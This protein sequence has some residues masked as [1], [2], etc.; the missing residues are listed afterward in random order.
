MIRSEPIQGG[1]V[2]SGVRGRF[3]FAA[4]VSLLLT[5][6]C[7]APAEPLTGSTL[8]WPD[9]WQERAVFEGP[10]VL[11]LATDAEQAAAG[12]D[13]YEDMLAGLAEV[14][15]QAPQPGLL[16][17]L[18]EDDA[19]SDFELESLFLQLS[20][21]GAPPDR[22]ERL[23]TLQ[24]TTADTLWALL[25][26]PHRL[27]PFGDGALAAH[28]RS[29]PRYLGLLRWAGRPLRAVLEDVMLDIMFDLPDQPRGNRYT[30]TDDIVEG[31]AKLFNDEPPQTKS[32]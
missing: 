28:A 4:A 21:T 31:R 16:F 15:D 25:A 10:G 32:A 23:L 14:H 6:G 1:S 17:V 8:R 5:V 9:G 3:R 7:R 30:V 26:D 19:L 22:V 13:R 18:G 12:I 20:A 24:R 29:L 11:V 27:P 2:R